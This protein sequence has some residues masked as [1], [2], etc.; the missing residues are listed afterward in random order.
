MKKTLILAVILAACAAVAGAQTYPGPTPGSCTVTIAAG[1]STSAVWAPLNSGGACTTSGNLTTQASIAWIRPPIGTNA[2]EAT[3]DALLIS[4]CT[5]SAGTD[6]VALADKDKTLITRYGISGGASP[7]QG[8]AFAPAD[9]AIL[10]PW[11]KFQ[12]VTSTNV[13]VVQTATR[14][15]QVIVRP[16]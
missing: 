2:L 7:T 10:G 6:C 8:I 12:T 3:T 15:F 13:A 16:Y 4:V 9:A 5:S 1:Q 11:L 14:T